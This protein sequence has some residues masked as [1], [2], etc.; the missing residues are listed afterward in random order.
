[1]LTRLTVKDLL[2]AVTLD[3]T[4]HL[5][6]DRV[7]RYVQTTEAIPPVV[8]LDTPDGRLLVDGHHRL[9]AAR[10]RG[11]VDIE[12]E[13]RAGS[14]HDALQ[15]AADKAAAERGMSRQEAI[16]YIKRLSGDRWGSH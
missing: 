6:P 9:A 16:D 4:A 10:R 8:V 5:N 2:V 13:V 12:A 1:V 14:R 7:A 15:Y 3:P 11:A